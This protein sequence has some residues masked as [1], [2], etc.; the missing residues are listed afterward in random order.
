ME[1]LQENCQ[2]RKLPKT[3]VA[4][5]KIAKTKVAKNLP[6][7]PL[8]SEIFANFQFFGNSFLCYIMKK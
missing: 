2:K 3:K 6:W 7:S 8:L 5:T 4:K 1:R